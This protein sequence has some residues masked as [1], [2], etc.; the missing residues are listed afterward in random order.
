MRHGPSCQGV[1]AHHAA[2]RVGDDKG[3]AGSAHGAFTALRT[4]VAELRLQPPAKFIDE[5]EGDGRRCAG[6]RIVRHLG[7]GPPVT[8]L[9][10]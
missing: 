10:G 3:A 9:A 5:V 1:V 7:D 4:K 2:R 6:N 8:P